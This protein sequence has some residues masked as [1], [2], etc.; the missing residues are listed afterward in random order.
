MTA[1][2]TFDP[3]PHPVRPAAVRSD[4]PQPA[5]AVNA[6]VYLRRRLVVGAVLV[7][8]GAAAWTLST[9]V[10]GGGVETV[11]AERSGQAAHEVHVV[12]PGDTLWSIAAGLDDDGDVRDTVDRLA[13]LNGGSAL[14]VGQRLLLD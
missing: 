1:T 11:G 5:H 3:R 12:A 9:W 6:A 14:T 8:I 7:L 2:L 4:Q 10:T 13:E